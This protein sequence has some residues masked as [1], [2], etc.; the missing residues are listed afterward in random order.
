MAKEKEPTT[1]QVIRHSKE[2]MSTFYSNNVEL[3][4][5]QWDLRFTFGEL[6][7]FTDGKLEVNNLVA[8]YMSPQH[9]KVFA[10]ALIKNI[11]SYEKQFGPIVSTED[12]TIEVETNDAE[13]E[14][15]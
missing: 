12:I 7:N 1:R 4:A 2:T 14:L 6:A 10:T 13:S 3:R 11:Q 8:V 5:T 15:E 9:A